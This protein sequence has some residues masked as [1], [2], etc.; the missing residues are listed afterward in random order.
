MKKTNF[1]ANLHAVGDLRYEECEYPTA[2]E[3]EVIVKIRACG[4]CGSD[5]GRVYKSGTYHFPTVI[6]HEF[7]GIVVE[8]AKGEFS[9]K[10]V[11][12]FPLLPCFTCESCQNQDYAT[13]HHYDYYG[14]RRDGGMSLFLAVKRFNL[15]PMPD[16]ISYE[17]GA[18]CEPASVARHAVLKLCM[19]KGERLLISG[20]GPIGIIAGQWAHSMGA[21]HV[22]YLD[23]DEEKLSFAEKMGFGIYRAGDVFDCVLEGTGVPTALETL[24]AALKPFGR[25]VLMGNPAGDMTLTQTGYWHILRKELTLLGTWNSSFS[26]KQNDWQASLAAMA[27]GTIS[28]S[29]LISHRYPL[30]A[31]NEAL[32][33]MK[34]K[35][36]LYHKVMLC[37]TEEAENE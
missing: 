12:V 29:P 23:I 16:G 30:S 14:S 13:C 6:G 26:E 33:M 31:V 25:A 32:A 2:K 3:D 37:M 10:R 11:A 34:E 27:T 8:D 22:S 24:L 20:A 5:L 7:S 21:E 4:V 15:L 19:Q 1:C 35:K 36:T 17:E 28:V 18:M 9:G